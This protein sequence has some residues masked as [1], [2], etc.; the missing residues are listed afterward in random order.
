MLT[1]HI[2]RLA[3]CVV[4]LRKA[5]WIISVCILMRFQILFSE[6]F[7]CPII[8]MFS[9]NIDFFFCDEDISFCP[10]W[11]LASTWQH[12][13]TT[14]AGNFIQKSF[15]AHWLTTYVCRSFAPFLR[16]HLA[17]FELA[18]ISSDYFESLLLPQL[19][20]GEND[21]KQ[22]DEFQASFEHI[23]IIF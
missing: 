7:S 13:R 21:S 22:S 17:C 11:T 5:L 9:V 10:P 4:G 23:L 6:T 2:F 19:L 1:H 16:M 12:Y 14:Y 18:L 8:I 20:R 3:A 15:Y